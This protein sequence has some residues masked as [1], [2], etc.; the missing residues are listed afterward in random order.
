MSIKYLQ[1]EIWTV[2]K[3]GKMIELL[4]KHACVR[5]RACVCG[6]YSSVN[7][8]THNQD[9]GNSKHGLQHLSL[10]C[11]LFFGLQLFF[12]VCCV[13]FR[14]FFSISTFGSFGS[15]DSCSLLRS[16]SSSFSFSSQSRFF[17]LKSSLF[18]DSQSISNKA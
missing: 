16:K 11:P 14:G 6:A 5:V 13:F 4:H 18:L 3:N 7:L 8:V 1:H 15:G 2:S 17:S 12:F 10:P 9:N